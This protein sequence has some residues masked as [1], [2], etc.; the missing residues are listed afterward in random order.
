MDKASCKNFFSEITNYTDN[1]INDIFEYD[2][3][4]SGFLTKENIYQ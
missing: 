3:D 1:K 4:E 2:K